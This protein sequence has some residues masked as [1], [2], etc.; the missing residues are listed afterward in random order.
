MG[1][2]LFQDYVVGFTSLCIPSSL[3]T[4]LLR[5]GK[6]STVS[7]KSLVTDCS[8]LGGIDVHQYSLDCVGDEACLF[9]TGLNAGLLQVGS[10]CRENT[11]VIPKIVPGP[12]DEKKKCSMEILL[13][14]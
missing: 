7:S 11:E 5:Y 10:R 4:G 6:L 13:V 14:V 3:L 9:S 12:L 2:E 1:P 8:S